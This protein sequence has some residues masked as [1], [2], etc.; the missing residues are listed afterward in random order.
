MDQPKVSRRR[1]ARYSTDLPVTVHNEDGAFQGRITQ[2]SRGGCLIYPSL[3]A[4]LPAHVKVTFNLSE[5]LPPIN[6]HGEIV[7]NIRD[8]GTG[9]A[10]IEISEAQQDAITEFFES[11]VPVSKI[12]ER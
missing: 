11:Q 3:P 6:C 12:A 2:I 10:L 7:Y 9:V 5:S 4:D 8:K 1:Y